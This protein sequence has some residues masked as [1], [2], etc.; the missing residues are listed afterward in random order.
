MAYGVQQ[1]EGALFCELVPNKYRMICLAITWVTFSPLIGVGPG[2]GEH[3]RQLSE[4]P[5]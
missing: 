3:D 5:Y 1:I 4:N 2:L